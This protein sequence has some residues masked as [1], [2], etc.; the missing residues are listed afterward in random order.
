MCFCCCVVFTAGFRLCLFYQIPRQ[1][2]WL[3]TW[4]LQ[5]HVHWWASHEHDR[6]PLSPW[7]RHFRINVL[8]NDLGIKTD[9]HRFTLWFEIFNEFNELIHWR[10]CM[11]V[12]HLY[13]MNLRIITEICSAT[14]RC[15]STFSN[16]FK[17]Q[18]K[19]MLFRHWKNLLLTRPMS[20]INHDVL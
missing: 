4:R 10:Q 7:A 16:C 15:L 1:N 17:W 8:N 3:I 19:E 12:A 14:V 18:P 5:V 2:V 20:V 9:D 13:R 6:S 11:N